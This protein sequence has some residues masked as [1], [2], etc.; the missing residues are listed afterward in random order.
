MEYNDHFNPADNND[1]DVP[2]YANNGDKTGFLDEP[3]KLDRGYNKIW[4]M[5]ERIDGTI[6]RTKIEIYTSSGIGSNIR[7]AETG[8][9]YPQIVGSEDEDLFFK[10]G[11]STGECTS[12]NGSNTLFYIS[13][14]HYMS[15]LG[16]TLSIDSINRWQEKKDYRMKQLNEVVKKQPLLQNIIVS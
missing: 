4:R 6:K 11:L 14:H 12:R 16:C 10:V 9:Y 8:E 1:Y 3:K 5:R 15:H 13:P 7:D 2:S